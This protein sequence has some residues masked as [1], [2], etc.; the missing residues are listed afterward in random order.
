VVRAKKLQPEQLE[1]K[2]SVVVGLSGLDAKTNLLAVNRQ[3]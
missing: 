1:L 2:K 3:P